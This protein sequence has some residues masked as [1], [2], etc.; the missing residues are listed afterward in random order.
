M[1]DA[2]RT[3]EKALGTVHYGLTEQQGN[4][5][6]FRRSLFAVRE[7]QAGEAFTAENM[8]SIRPGNGLHP[9]HADELLGH[10]AAC[11]IEHG[12]P[13]SWEHVR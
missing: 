7:I 6:V 1:V 13:L 12:T 5:R 11:H 2:I 8:R 10:S 3:T 9:R 4:S